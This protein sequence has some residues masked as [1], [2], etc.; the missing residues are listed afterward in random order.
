MG[1][2]FGFLGWFCFE[3][4]CGFIALVIGVLVGGIWLIVYSSANGEISTTSYTEIQ[5]LATEYPDE[6]RP[7]VLEALESEGKI[8]GKEHSA[9]LKR[10]KEL[11]KGQISRSEPPKVKECEETTGSAE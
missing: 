11:V 7:M 9:I 5:A 6:I 1:G 3:T 10:H 8:I 2:I 4:P